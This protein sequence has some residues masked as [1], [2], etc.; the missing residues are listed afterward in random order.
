MTGTDP[1]PRE[2]GPLLVGDV[3]H[4]GH[5]VARLV[6]G[7][8][9]RVVFVRHALPGE[10][11]R[12]R[13]T[14]TSQDR[15][16]RG[17]AIE[18]LEPSPDRVRAR[19]PISGPGGCGGCDFQHVELGAQRRLKQTV[20]AEQLQRLAGIEWTGEVEPVTSPGTEDGLGWRTRMRYHVDGSGR[21][22]LRAHRSHAV[23][24]V[25]SGGCPIAAPAVAAVAA[26]SWEPG[27]ELQVAQA[28][29]DVAVV[30]RRRLLR[31]PEVLGEHAA[32]HDFAVAATGFWQV[33]PAAADTL[34][35]AVLDGLAP[36][37]AERVFDLYCGAG[38]F[39]AALSDVG[40][41]V[42]GVESDRT[43]LSHARR[44]VPGARFTAGRV[45]QVLRRLP[46]RTELVVLDPPRTGAGRQ[47][48]L[49]VIE[50]RPRAIAYVA[51]DPAALGRDLAYAAAAG[52]LPTGIRAFD[53]FPMT[54]H[55]E[56]VAILTRA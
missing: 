26:E 16:W 51:C 32:G 21:V 23:L 50:R 12:V 5:C 4:G 47:V 10:R 14:D 8:G 2:V 15:F 6:D 56:C 11:V 30:S 9:S 49:D 45:D 38:L 39:A 36:D 41:R 7:A 35:R 13:L 54:H 53:L 19:C 40:C 31:G 17:D 29:P 42:W 34:V 27:A 37:P 22:G 25:P 3:A 28:T 46:R 24:P 55:V 48:L 33:H 44:N 18:I 1:A 20:V 43:A 52:Y